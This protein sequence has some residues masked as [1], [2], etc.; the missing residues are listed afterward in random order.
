M[1]MFIS[2]VVSEF[3]LGNS[4]RQLPLRRQPYLPIGVAMRSLVLELQLFQC[5]NRP[6]AVLRRQKA[7]DGK[8]RRKLPLCGL[9]SNRRLAATPCRQTGP[10]TVSWR[11]FGVSFYV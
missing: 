7:V 4:L 2:L 8:L 6:A 10:F 5:L 9:R 1:K 3:Q 11:E